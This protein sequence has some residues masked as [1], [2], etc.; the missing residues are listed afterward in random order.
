MRLLT[1]VLSALLTS[2]SA[3]ALAQP[4]PSAEVPPRLQHLAEE[5]AL[6]EESWR[7]AAESAW[8]GDRLAH[9]LATPLAGAWLEL[10]ACACVRDGRAA[11]AGLAAT[12]LRAA[13]SAGAG[14]AALSALER[15]LRERLPPLPD[16]DGRAA[17]GRPASWAPARASAVAARLDA[18]LLPGRPEARR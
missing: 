6:L 8:E 4:L 12:V 13:R 18:A 10:E 16:G 5:L 11:A 3:T 15:Q 1:A 9:R 14:P 2:W 7:A 17:A